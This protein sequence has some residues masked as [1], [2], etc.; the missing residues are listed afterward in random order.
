MEAH[1]TFSISKIFKKKNINNYKEHL[2]M[3]KNMTYRVTINNNASLM[4]N[5]YIIVSTQT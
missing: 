4:K 1:Y 3:S 2:E 5:I